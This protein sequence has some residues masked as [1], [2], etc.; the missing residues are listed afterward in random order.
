MGI[1][2]AGATIVKNVDN[3][4]SLN[5]LIFNAA[6]QGTANATPGY[7][8]A[9][10]GAANFYSATTGWEINSTNWQSGLHASNGV[11]TCPVAGIYAMGYNGI[12]KGGSGLPAGFNTY[13]YSAFAKNGV[14]AYHTHWNQGATGTTV[15]HSGGCS[16]LFSCAAGDTL[17]LFVNRAPSPAGP[18]VVSQ[19]YGLYPNEHH[20]V[21]CRL[22]G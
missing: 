13:G 9:K 3:G 17:A 18:D 11:F 12:H 10:S 2:I 7:L 8:G 22:V 21:W 14:V 1:D 20:A 15:W 4:V 16:A 5:S 6:G 19:N